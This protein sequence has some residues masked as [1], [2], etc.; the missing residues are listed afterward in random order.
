M[1]IDTRESFNTN[2]A[3]ASTT[4]VKKYFTKRYENLNGEDVRVLESLSLELDKVTEFLE[5]QKVK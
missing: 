3:I 2:D 4:K 5:Q 1:N